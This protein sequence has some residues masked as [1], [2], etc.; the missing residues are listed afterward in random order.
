VW[1]ELGESDPTVVEHGNAKTEARCI[2]LP[3]T[4]EF[5]SLRRSEQNG[6]PWS[7]H[8]DHLLAGHSLLRG[9]DN[10]CGADL[11]GNIDAA[12]VVVISIQVVH[13]AVERTICPGNEGSAHS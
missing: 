11:I 9:T 12:A 8:P 13:L 7:N 3:R 4:R 10:G 1:V 6:R 2:Y 5:G